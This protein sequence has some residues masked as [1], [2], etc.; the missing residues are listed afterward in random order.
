MHLSLVRS[1]VTVQ[2]D[3]DATSLV[4]LL[5]KRYPGSQWYISTHDAITS[6]EAF[7]VHVHRAAFSM[8]YTISAT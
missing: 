1:A 7:G 4:I 3:C 6:K 8:G 5:R 2:V